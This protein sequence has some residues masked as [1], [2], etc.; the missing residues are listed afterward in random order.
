[1][2]KEFLGFTRKLRTVSFDTDVISD[3]LALKLLS[4]KTKLSNEEQ[5]YF[6][7]CIMS[8]Q[9]VSL[10]LSVNVKTVGTETVRKE[11]D[12]MPKLKQIH[13]RI[14]DETIFMSPNKR[15]LALRYSNQ[16]N[17]KFGD[18]LIIA[19][20][21]DSVDCLLSWNRKHIVNANT[22]R[23]IRKI[24]DSANLNNAADIN[25]GRFCPKN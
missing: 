17:I 2:K 23:T 20:A 8:F 10:V 3:L 15:R 18:A 11:L 4:Q 14:F 19:L 25:S 21:T 7:R 5:S 22:L 16:T 9:V 24:N 6:K 12:V 13:E 1:M